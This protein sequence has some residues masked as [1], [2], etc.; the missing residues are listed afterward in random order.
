MVP[1][2]R[3]AIVQPAAHTGALMGR[4]AAALPNWPTAIRRYLV[5]VGI[6]NLVWEGAQLPLYTLWRTDP[7]RA[8]A[9]AILHCTAGDVVIAAVVLLLAL[10]LFG[11][12]TWP[13]E[14][15]AR[16]A[17]AVV[18]LGIGYTVYSEYVNTVLRQTW[19]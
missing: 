6:L 2:A 13:R 3:E 19:T 12:A 18:T 10:A 5:A 11:C 15:R 1:E 8:Q 9:F 16:V 7:P 17:A 4:E 14:C